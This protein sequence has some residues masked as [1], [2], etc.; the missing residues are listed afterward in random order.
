MTGYR[1]ALRIALHD[2]LRAK[3]RTA[4]ILCMIGLPVAAVVALGTVWKT[5]DW[6]PRESLP[7][8]IGAADARLTSTGRDPIRQLDHQSSIDLRPGPPRPE[9]RPWTTAEVARLATA[10]YGPDARVLSMVLGRSVALAT[11]AGPLR[12]PLTELDVRDPMARGILEITEGRA[13]AT[14]DE[15]ALSPSLA[16]RGLELGGTV[17][18]DRAGTPKRIVGYVR[19]PYSPRGAE[20]TEHSALTLPAAIPAAPAGSSADPADDATGSADDDAI[21]QWLVDAGEAVTRNDI[22]AFNAGGFMVLCLEAVENP[23][24][25]PESSGPAS[26]PDWPLNRTNAVVVLAVAMVMLQVVL[27]AGPAFAVDV[28]RRR[29]LLALV[30]VAGG[31][32]RHLRAVVLAGGLLLGSAGALGGLL[33]GIAAGAVTGEVVRAATDAADRPVGPFD[34]PWAAVAATVLLGTA[35]GLVAAYFPARQAARMDVVAALAGRRDPARARSGRRRAVAGAALAAAGVLCCLF[36]VRTLREFGAAGGAAAI[37]VGTV[38]TVPWLVG[39]LGGVAGRLPVPLRLAVRD[40]ARNRARTAPAVAAIM[41]AVAG[42]TALAIA[43]AGDLKQARELYKAELPQGSALIWPT[44]EKAPAA[45]TARDV[46]GGDVTGGDVTG[47]DRTVAAWAEAV[48]RNDA[49]AAEVRAAIEREVP[50]LPLLDLPILPG[51]TCTPPVNPACHSVTFSTGYRGGG[52]A[53]H[54]LET[55]VGGAAE[56]RM[57]LGREVPEVTEALAAGKIV[58]FG[59]RT[60]P[61]ES[62]TATVQ[63]WEQ[64]RPKPRTL[65]QVTGLPAVTVAMDAHVRALVPPSAAGRIGVPPRVAAFGVDAAEHRTTEP[66]AE[67]VDE[68]LAGFDGTEQGRVYVERGFDRTEGTLMSVLAAVAAV[69]TLG[70]ALIATGLSAADARPDL[71]VLAAIGA[72]PRTRRLLAAGQAA[73]VAVLGC[74]LGIAAGFVPGIAASRALTEELLDGPSGQGPFFDVPWTVL[75]VI[76]VAVP[77]VTALVA[78]LCVRSRLPGATATRA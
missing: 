4:L 72:R 45:R 5:L 44:L 66:E 40:G 34:V 53:S 9:T 50:G 29:R 7:H 54:A 26:L 57:L 68:L 70:G 12:V 78:G 22:A 74:W 42:A 69:L 71:A 48:R 41:A 19:D 65:R 24:D 20:P 62:T 8:E 73:F 77:L 16:G 6:S 51:H 55:V 64:G 23:L 21:R 47:G 59:A 63:V 33:L 15:I 49:R 46:T 17:R 25:E 35:A 67:R 37:I 75:L 28:R 18:V 11:S 60:P 61:T 1:P 36:G 13:P 56:A 39:A 32:P 2:A 3:G 43:N 76:G 27:L 58:V 52:T 31:G 10:L 14:P 30:A 38:L